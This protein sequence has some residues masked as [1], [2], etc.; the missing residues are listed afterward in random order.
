MGNLCWDLVTPETGWEP[1]KATKELC[2]VL[3]WTVWRL[4]LLRELQIFLPRSG[5]LSAA[6]RSSISNIITLWS[7]L[8]LMSNLFIYWLGTTRNYWEFLTWTNHRRTP[9]SKCIPDTRERSSELS[10][11][12]TINVLWAVQRIRQW[13][14]GIVRLASLCK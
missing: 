12:E 11:V 3:H 2:G 1:L 5:T 4:S 14:F 8:H 7:R 10:S 13:K 6:K 9:Q